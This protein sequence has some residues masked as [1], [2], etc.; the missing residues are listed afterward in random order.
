M[1]SAQL[2]RFQCRLSPSQTNALAAEQ[3]LAARNRPTAS[4][5]PGGRFVRRKRASLRRFLRSSGQSR[6]LGRTGRITFNVARA[7]GEEAF[8]FACGSG[9]L[10]E[11]VITDGARTVDTARLS[12]PG[13]PDDN[14]TLFDRRNYVS[15]AAHESP[16]IS[17]D[18][19]NPV[20]FRGVPYLLYRLRSAGICL[21][22]AG[23]SGGAVRLAVVLQST[24]H[25][26][27]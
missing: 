7:G 17:I 12:R 26:P 13:P 11:P 21:Y 6:P 5:R 23:K 27:A 2:A 20:S 16:Y 15:V 19:T 22:F 25:R 9:D 10:I 18:M 24:D 3:Q 8:V 4:D 1:L 14:T